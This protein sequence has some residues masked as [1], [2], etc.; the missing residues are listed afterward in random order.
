MNG[1]SEAVEGVTLHRM[2]ISPYSGHTFHESPLFLVFYELLVTKD[3][4]TI[5]NLFIL[6]DIITALILSMVCYKQLN[7]LIVSEEERFHKDIKKEDSK[8]LSIDASQIK[9]LSLKV[10]AIYLLSP[11]SLLSCV[12]QSTSVFTNFL[13]ASFLLSSTLQMRIISTALLALLSYQCFYPLMMI[14]P[15]A[16]II[17]DHKWRNSKAMR[18]SQKTSEVQYL[19]PSVRYSMIS[20]VLLFLVFWLALLVFSYTL[21]DKDY[22]FLYSTYGFV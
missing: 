20:T 4:Q 9:E 3:N 22:E 21:M 13:M 5:G 8:R 17:E 16:M 15:L 6:I 11:Y 10:A 19:S 7:H 12:G 18:N 1:L 14:V 2:A